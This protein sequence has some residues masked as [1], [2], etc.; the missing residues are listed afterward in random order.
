MAGSSLQFKS[1]GDSGDSIDVKIF[2]AV[3]IF[4]CLKL[5]KLHGVEWIFFLKKYVYIYTLYIY[6]TVFFAFSCIHIY[7]IERSLGTISFRQVIYI[8]IPEILKSGLFRQFNTLNILHISTHFS[9]FTKNHLQRDLHLPRLHPESTKVY[10][11]RSVCLQ[12]VLPS[13]ILAL[14]AAFFSA[15]LKLVFLILFIYVSKKNLDTSKKSPGNCL[16]W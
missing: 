13:L 2:L 6:S 9:D 4:R 5:L 11:L 3:P 10:Q 7:M 12:A 14:L 8:N 16:F 1:T 15:E